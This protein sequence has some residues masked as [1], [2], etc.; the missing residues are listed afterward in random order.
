MRGLARVH[1]VMEFYG[2]LI[3]LLKGFIIGSVEHC[4][5]GP[6]DI[7]FQKRHTIQTETVHQAPKGY[8]LNVDSVA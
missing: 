5:F 1:E 8:S 3:H 4:K 2:D 7:D 6:L